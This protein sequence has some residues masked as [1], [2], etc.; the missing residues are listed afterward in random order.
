MENILEKKEKNKIILVSIIYIISALLYLF[1][2]IGSK[3]GIFAFLGNFRVYVLNGGNQLLFIAGIPIILYTCFASKSMKKTFSD[4]KFKKIPS[5]IVGLSFLTGITLFGMIFLVSTVWGN[6]VNLTGYKTPL[7]NLNAFSTVSVWE[8]FLINTILTCVFPALCEEILLRGCVLAGFEKMGRKKAIVLVGLLFGLLHV[9]VDQVFYATLMGM[10]LC[11]FTMMTGSIWPAIIMHFTSN[12]CSVFISFV[13][14]LNLFDGG[15]NRFF[16]AFFYGNALISVFNFVVVGFFSVSVFFV[17]FAKILKY[18][19]TKSLYNKLEAILAQNNLQIG[20]KIEINVE[21]SQS[22]IDMKNLVQ[23]EI[24]MQAVSVRRPFDFILPPNENDNYK[25]TM[26]E[27]AFVIAA[28]L[29]T[30][31]ATLV[32]FIGGLL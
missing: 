11:L 17:L 31:V 5:K 27:W 22:L 29:L 21:T 4:F 24:F 14:K 28:I 26:L 32:S 15:F 19:K 8:N 1:V 12:F 30:G 2:R 23:N 13:E 10:I 25:M 3:F 20:E 7:F 9:N 18:S 16:E 6:L